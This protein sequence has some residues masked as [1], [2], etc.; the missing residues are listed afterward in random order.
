MSTIEL[1]ARKAEI[2]RNILI[3]TDERIV[4]GLIEWYRNSKCRERAN[5]S[6]TVAGLLKLASENRIVADNYKFNRE[7]C[8]D[9]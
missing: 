4:D 3:E 5:K 1:E 9:R 7:A 6:Q 2:A 8:Y